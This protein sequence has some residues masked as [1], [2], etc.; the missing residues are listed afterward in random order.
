MEF[1]TVIGLEIHAQV[2]SKTGLFCGCS[3]D[4]FGQQANI[5]VCP[6]C[7]GFPGALPYPNEDALEKGARAAL[8]LNCTVNPFSKFDRKNYFYP[9]L[10]LGFQ[11]SQYD[12]PVSENGSVQIVHDGEKKTIRITRLHL[13]NDAGKLTHTGNATLLDYNRSG[14]PL[15]EIVSEPDIR[16]SEEARIFAEMVQKILRYVGSSDCDMEKGMMRFDASVSIRPKGSDELN[17][18]AEIKNLNS[19]RS[20]EA[21][22]DYEVKRQIKLWEAGTPLS[23]EQTVGWDDDRGTTEL[24]REKESAADYRYF[25]EPDLPPIEFSL[26]QI[27]QWKSELPELPLAKFERFQS[28]YKLNDFEA[29]FYCENLTLAELFEAVASKTDDVK[30]ANSFIGTILVK[31]LKDAKISIEDSPVKADHL[32]ELIQMINAGDISNNV[33]KSTVFEAMMKNGKM[34]SEIVDEEGLKQV[35]DSSAIEDFCKAAI[36]ALPKAAEDVKN[37]EMKAIGALVGHVMK[38]SKGSANPKMVNEVLKKLL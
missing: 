22:I 12:Q 34:P 33:A 4:S 29:N 15:M 19:F 35:S 17:P 1:E 21:A 30:S 36:E 38:L 9:D 6:V 25:P 8:A 32:I 14:T 27:E 31:A 37:G 16:S 18:R 23:G 13:E 11:I 10:P 28:E 2:S 24:M 26:G 3:L 7:M 5:N 20:L